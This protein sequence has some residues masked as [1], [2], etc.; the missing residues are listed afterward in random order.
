M[1]LGARQNGMLKRR[2]MT[3]LELSILLISF[4]TIMALGM[5][6]GYIHAT[7]TIQ[8]VI[9][10][11]TRTVEVT[12][13]ITQEVPVVLEKI[14]YKDLEPFDSELELANFLRDDQTNTATTGDC[15]DY[16]LT[17]Q[18]QAAKIG[19]R[20][21]FYVT[22]PADYNKWFEERLTGT[23]HHAINLA[24][25]GNKIYLIEPQTDEW[26]WVYNLD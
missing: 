3:K 21:D 24:I 13:Y 11:E 22:I 10:Q 6:A 17:L 19:K 5:L 7:N 4:T 9:I 1:M 16:A 25:I 23:E 15:D 14:V 8:P 20:M 12:K 18:S 26:H 2:K